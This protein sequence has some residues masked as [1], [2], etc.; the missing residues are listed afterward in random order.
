MHYIRSGKGKPLLLIHSLG[1]SCRSRS[2]ILDDLAVEGE[3]I[4]IDL[5]G[6]EK[7]RL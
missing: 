4:A 6:S 2:P 7:R 1:G 3:F 5:P